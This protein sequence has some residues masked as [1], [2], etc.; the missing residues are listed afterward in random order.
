MVCTGTEQMQRPF[1]AGRA[2]SKVVC[3]PHFCKG[4]GREV[5]HTWSAQVLS[6]CSVLLVRGG[7]VAKWSARYISYFCKGKGREGLESLGV[8][9]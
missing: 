7:P 3:T 2:C 6:K 1:S 8:G 9:A 5:Q 4:K